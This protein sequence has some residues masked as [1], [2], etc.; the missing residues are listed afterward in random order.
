MKTFS[1]LF[2]ASLLAATAM[3]QTSGVAAGESVTSTT[4]SGKSE[5]RV[6]PARIEIPPEKARPITVPKIALAVSIDGRV[7][8]EEWQNAALFKD[9][10]QTSPGE[11]IEAS[12]PTEVLMMYDE[13]HLY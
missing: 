8:A 4:T 7:N 6:K 9:F 11:N 13:K 10:Y 1:L 12:K 3:A 5:S 2:A